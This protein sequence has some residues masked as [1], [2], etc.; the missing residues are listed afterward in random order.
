M[1]G[2]RR[3]LRLGEY[4]VRL[5][6]Q[7]LPQ[8][9]REERYREWA[10]ELPAILHDPQVRPALRR[11][12]RMLGYAADTVRG[13]ALAPGRTR[14]WMPRLSAAF[15]LLL[16]VASLV[17]VASGAWLIVHAPGN[18]QGYLALAWALP[19][20]VYFIRKRVRP[21]GRMTMVLAISGI[22]GLVAWNVAQGPGDWVN[23]FLAALLGLILLV[24]LLLACYFLILIALTWWVRIRRPAQ[25]EYHAKHS[26]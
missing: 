21:A 19:F 14:G 11:A 2:E 22:P 13:A 8:D 18:A 26:K 20:A 10:A 23:Y 3:L 1:T 12:V 17:S 7:R 5:A 24:L 25:G 16:L 6:C 15:Y 4:L 9:I